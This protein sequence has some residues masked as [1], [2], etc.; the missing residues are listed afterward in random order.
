MPGSSRDIVLFGLALAIAPVAALTAEALRQHG[1]LAVWRGAALVFI[2]FSTAIAFLLRPHDL[3]VLGIL[4]ALGMLAGYLGLPVLAASWFVDAADSATLGPTERVVIGT[5]G[6][7][8]VLMIATVVFG[9]LG[10]A[11]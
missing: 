11:L 4:R 8:A 6:G 7:G 1:R 10:Y 9:L 3:D 5:L 2:G